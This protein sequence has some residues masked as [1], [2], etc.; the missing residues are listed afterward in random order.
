[1]YGGG[2][3]SPSISNTT[4]RWHSNDYLTGKVGTTGTGNSSN[5]LVHK[6]LTPT[7]TRPWSAGTAAYGT[8][9]ENQAPVRPMMRESPPQRR[10][11]SGWTP[12]SGM[13]TAGPLLSSG[14]TTTPRGTYNVSPTRTTEDWRKRMYP[15][16]HTATHIDSS[17]SG[18][19]SRAP[20]DS[21]KHIPSASE[22]QALRNAVVEAENRAN[23]ARS[24]APTSAAVN[25]STMPAKPAA[26]VPGSG[27]MPSPPPPRPS[28]YAP[29]L[30]SHSLTSQA[31]AVAPPVQK[32]VIDSDLATEIRSLLRELSV[33]KN[34]HLGDQD[35]KFT[36]HCEEVKKSISAISETQQ[37]ELLELK[38][39]I[40]NGGSEEGTTPNI[41][42]QF[43]MLREGIAGLSDQINQS[44]LETAEK[45]EKVITSKSSSNDN[46]SLE[47]AVALLSEQVKVLSDNQQHLITIINQKQSEPVQSSNTQ[48]ANDLAATVEA[49]RTEV[50]DV[51]SQ[52][53]LLLEAFKSLPTQPTG[54]STSGGGD[55]ANSDEIKELL[56]EIKS[57]RE[58]FLEMITKREKLADER[59]EKLKVREDRLSS[60]YSGSPSPQRF[61]KLHEGLM[62]G[63]HGRS[64]VEALS[65][66]GS[67]GSEKGKALATW[68]PE[69]A[70]LADEESDTLNQ[71]IDG[72]VSGITDDQTEESWGVG[73]DPNDPHMMA[74]MMSQMDPSGMGGIPPEIAMGV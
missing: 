74:H 57:D 9:L 23:I 35:T 39:M 17:S 56:S 2:L 68:I 18:L 28:A 71:T 29:Q 64:G 4:S 31:P 49:L 13:S 41:Q 14:A 25:V 72:E 58:H 40:R 1:M 24:P 10:P 55:A 44:S 6:S 12:S 59:E 16:S 54:G 63:V 67:E 73:I 32:S 22:I 11:L 21:K 36:S 30:G 61:N 52:Q 20:T 15:H 33:S 48:P 47:Q 46:T 69:K 37:K 38:E 51:T 3:P 45:V 34:M 65:E 43:D 5:N 50:G 66:S 53:Q 60:E 27:R 26:T 42:Q 8:E 7:A 70:E 62:P 19:T